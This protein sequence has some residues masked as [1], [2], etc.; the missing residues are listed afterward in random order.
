MKVQVGVGEGRKIKINCWLFYFCRKLGIKISDFCVS[1]FSLRSITSPEFP[2]SSFT[3]GV[4]GISAI[5]GRT[6]TI[7]NVSWN[8]CF[9]S[10][11]A[12]F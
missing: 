1:E 4:H 12:V 7:F 10:S 3:L 11:F 2:K 9:S 8:L 6:D 5:S